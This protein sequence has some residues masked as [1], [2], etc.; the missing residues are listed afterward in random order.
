MAKGSADLRKEELL[1]S[2]SP[3]TPSGWNVKTGAIACQSFS[4]LLLYSSHIYPILERNAHFCK[5][6]IS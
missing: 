6:Y 1:E 5:G 2:P 4:L 3:A